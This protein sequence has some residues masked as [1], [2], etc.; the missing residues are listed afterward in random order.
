MNSFAF[1][2]QMNNS[3]VKFSC[4]R[5]TLCNIIS[6]VQVECHWGMSRILNSTKIKYTSSV[7]REISTLKVD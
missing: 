3:W 6:T 4:E 5:L 2:M 1:A 7:F